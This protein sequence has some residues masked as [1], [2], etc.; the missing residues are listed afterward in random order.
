MENYKIISGSNCNGSKSLTIN[1]FGNE[2]IIWGIDC[3]TTDLITQLDLITSMTSNINDVKKHL[4]INGFD[5]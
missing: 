1:V 3:E 2:L 4:E 5:I